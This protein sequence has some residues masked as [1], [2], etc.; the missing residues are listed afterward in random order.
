M[1]QPPEIQQ[2]QDGPRD[3]PQSETNVTRHDATKD[4]KSPC[5][6]TMVKEKSE[7][8]QQIQMTFSETVKAPHKKAPVIQKEESNLSPSISIDNEDFDYAS[9]DSDEDDSVKS[10]YNKKLGLSKE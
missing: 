10:I 8:A 2:D 9:S 7:T 1:Y 6:P 3:T 4:V 5:V